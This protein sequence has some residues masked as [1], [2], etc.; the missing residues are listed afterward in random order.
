MSETVRSDIFSVR[1]SD[2]WS[3][4]GYKKATF[5]R[6]VIDALLYSGL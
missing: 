3:S 6:G 4:V 2:C 5:L 1:T